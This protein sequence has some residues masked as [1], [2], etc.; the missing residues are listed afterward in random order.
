MRVRARERE[1]SE[2]VSERVGPLNSPGGESEEGES[3]RAS[4]RE[5]ERERERVQSGGLFLRV[6]RAAMSASDC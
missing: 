5:R 4:G 2:G 1:K 6:S 3:E